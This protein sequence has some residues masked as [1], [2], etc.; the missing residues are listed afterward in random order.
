LK[1]WEILLGKWVGAVGMYASLLAFS[2]LNL[3]FLFAYGKPDWQPLAVGYLGLLLQ[4][5]AML[6]LGMFL[7][8]VTQNQIAAAFSTFVLLLML[9]VF[10]WMSNMDQNVVTEVLTYVSLLRH[11]ESFIK[12][13]L[14]L[15]DILYYASVSFLGLFLTARSLE[16]LRYRG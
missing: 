4:G 11:N 3:I 8:S 10:E 5:A 12:G 9:W 13:V 16:S 7:S 1:D 14:D 15:K 6:A 2:G